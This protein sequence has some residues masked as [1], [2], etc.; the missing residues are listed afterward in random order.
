LRDLYEILG[1]PKDADDDTIKRAYRAKARE[2]HPD[3]GGDEEHFKELTGA[4]EILSNAQARANYDQYGDPR[5]PGGQGGTG[6]AGFG[7]LQD[8][9][10]A[11]FGGM[12]GRGRA[13][14]RAPRAGRDAMVDVRLT[15]EEAASGIR[16]EVELTL[17]RTCDACGGSGAAPGSGPVRCQTCGGA[18]AVQQ[19]T[20]SIFGQMLSTTTC[21]SCH[22]EGTR[23]ADPCKSCHGAGRR[24]GNEVVTVDIPAGVAE[25]TRLR[26]NGRG[27]PGRP[28][29]PAGDLYV[30]VRVAEHA[31][32]NRDGDDLH[33]E[34]RLPMSQAALG[35]EIK[36]PTLF[37]EE[38]VAV[39]A[40]VQSGEVLTLRGA[41][42]PRLGSGA[43]GRLHIHVRVVTP[44]DLTEDQEELLR[45]FAAMRQEEVRE[46]S[47]GIFGRLREAFGG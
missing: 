43:K 25:G 29:S 5:G 41:G 42:M 30:R 9:I 6:F 15:L 21:P 13:G 22:G 40:G 10:D 3:A 7:D 8:I 26:L 39:P 44:T 36:V 45:H 46:A 24:E 47:R 31:V 33:C 2:L 1:V 35:A 38:T 19:M 23:I 14:G 12:G 20:R 27:E 18:G 37:G 16:R 28:G 4:Y 32:F 17:P 34:L 11:F